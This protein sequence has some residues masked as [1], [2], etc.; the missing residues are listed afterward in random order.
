[1][2]PEKNHIWFGMDR[3]SQQKSFA[4]V[5]RCTTGSKTKNTNTE[6]D[7]DGNKFILNVDNLILFPSIELFLYGNESKQNFQMK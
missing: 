4:R 2:N 6:R 1:M 5:L 7:N 3:N